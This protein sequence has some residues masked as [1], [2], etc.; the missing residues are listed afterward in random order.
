MP[1]AGRRRGAAVSEG[2]RGAEAVDDLAVQFAAGAGI[3]RVEGLGHQFSGHGGDCGETLHLQ[4]V[5]RLQFQG[6]RAAARH[7]AND[8]GARVEFNLQA[9]QE[10]GVPDLFGARLPGED[11]V[12][13]QQFHGVPFLLQ[14]L[15]QQEEGPV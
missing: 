11:A 2:A 13:P 9:R 4:T 3:P 1:K 10:Q 12:A 5:Q 7:D 14:P 8:A 6:G 15:A